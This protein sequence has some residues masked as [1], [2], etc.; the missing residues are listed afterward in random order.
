MEIG[1]RLNVLPLCL[2]KWLPVELDKRL[3]TPQILYGPDDDPSVSQ[4]TSLTELL[5]YC[6]FPLINLYLVAN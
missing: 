3:G 6:V 4:T 5:V 2:G 1:H